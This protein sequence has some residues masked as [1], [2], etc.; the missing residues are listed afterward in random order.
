MAEGSHGRH[1][2]PGERTQALV[3]PDRLHP[4]P[5]QIVGQQHRRPLAQP[6][7]AR[8]VSGLEWHDEHAGS[9]G[10]LRNSLFLRGE[11]RETYQHEAERAT[12]EVR[13]C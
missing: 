6:P 8:I 5:A 12:K 1:L 3:A 13:S 2:Q 9:G 11:H 4:K 10:A 7:G